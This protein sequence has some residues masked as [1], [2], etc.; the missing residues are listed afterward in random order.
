MSAV[1][2]TMPRASCRLVAVVAPLFGGA[3]LEPAGSVVLAEGA[4]TERLRTRIDDF[5]VARF[6]ARAD[7]LAATAGP[8]EAMYL[9]TEKLREMAANGEAFFG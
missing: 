7:E 5:G 4:G 8:L 2:P 6:V 3:T 1:T 9:P